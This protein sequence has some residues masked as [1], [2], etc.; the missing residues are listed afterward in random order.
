M[1][2]LGFL[3]LRRINFGNELRSTVKKI[4]LTKFLSNYTVYFVLQKSV[5]LAGELKNLF[6][7]CA[8]Q[9]IDL[10]S[11]VLYF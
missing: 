9:Q 7:H 10:A 4:L 1:K 5:G 6:N 2:M 3:N 8:F 11:F